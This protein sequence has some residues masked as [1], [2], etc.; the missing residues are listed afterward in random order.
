MYSKARN[1]SGSEY[2]QSLQKKLN[3]VGVTKF[4]RAH[5]KILDEIIRFHD[6]VEQ[7]T[8]RKPT[9]KDWKDIRS[10]IGFLL[11]YTESHFRDEEQEMRRLNYPEM[12]EHV[13]QHREFISKIK[14]LNAKLEEGQAMYVVDMK[15]YLLDWLFSHINRFDMR[16]KK[17][18]NENGIR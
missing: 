8:T 7:L 3:D 1:I 6:L 17:F 16:Y 4:N 5:Q 15:F 12:S 18:F 13:A 14:E 9:D 10:I 2:R 11:N